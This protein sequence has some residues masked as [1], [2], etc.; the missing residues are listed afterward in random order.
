MSNA[1]Q[2]SVLALVALGGAAGAVSRHS[3]T[4]LTMRQ[5]VA[6]GVPVGVPLANILGGF[7]I[8]FLAVTLAQFIG[9][10]RYAPLLVTGF[11]GGFTTFSAF[12][13][14]T[15][16]LWERGRADLAVGY[17]LVSVIGSLGAAALG[18]L[19]ARAVFSGS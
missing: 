16:T 5:S 3:L 10:N 19:A 18:L 4:A 14:E 2:P 6:W 13:L 9:A 1:F 17:V 12:S 8:G 15:L 11:L 7:A